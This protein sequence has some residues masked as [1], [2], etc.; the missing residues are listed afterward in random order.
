LTCSN[1]AIYITPFYGFQQVFKSSTPAAATF[2]FGAKRH[3]DN[4]SK[5]DCF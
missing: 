1:I 4:D 5:I 2:Q 3:N